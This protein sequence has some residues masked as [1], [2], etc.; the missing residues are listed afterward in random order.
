MI[1]KAQFAM[2]LMNARRTFNDIKRDTIMKKL[3]YNH[4]EIN[5]FI[6]QKIRKIRRYSGISQEELALYLGVIPGQLH[7]YEVAES[8]ISAATLKEVIK[9]FDIRASFFFYGMEKYISSRM[10]NVQ[11]E[12]L[13]CIL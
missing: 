1:C 8:Y 4:P 10:A 9:Y 7:N 12:N 13:L 3:Q 5:K 6:G 2:Q 11:V